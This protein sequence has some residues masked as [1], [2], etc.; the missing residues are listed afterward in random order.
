MGLNPWDVAAGIFLIKT[1]GG[2]I[3][4]FEGNEDALSGR[5]IVASNS[6]L[7]AWLLEQLELDPHFA[8]G[9]DAF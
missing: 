1:A 3:S 7:H 9:G 8:S 4:D 6:H 2:R 5:Q